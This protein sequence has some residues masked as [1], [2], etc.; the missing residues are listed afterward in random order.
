M[1]V[2]PA[3]S[4]SAQAGA[5]QRPQNALAAAGGWQRAFCEIKLT[6][7]HP[8][9]FSASVPNNPAVTGTVRQL[10]DAAA[11]LWPPTR[12]T[13]CQGASASGSD[14][15]SA[16]GGE[17]SKRFGER[18]DEHRYLFP[19]EHYSALVSHFSKSLQ[20]HF[21]VKLKPLPKFLLQAL[22]GH[23]SREATAH[24]AEVRL[25]R[26]NKTLLEKLLPFQRKGVLRG[27]QQKGPSSPFAFC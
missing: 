2:P 21:N 1:G 6:L 3:A 4:R 18:A 22:E 26:M 20:R 13:D 11:D 8:D 24:D 25:G 27:L 23:E 9:V 5:P 16:S 19:M 7:V 10:Y 15:S 14:V 17:R 12:P